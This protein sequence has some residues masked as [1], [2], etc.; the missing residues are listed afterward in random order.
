MDADGQLISRFRQAFERGGYPPN[1]RVDRL[2]PWLLV[3][4]AL[5]PD[6][7]RQLVEAGVTH[8]VDLRAEAMDEAA[9]FHELGIRWHRIPVVDRAA[10]S[11][12]QLDELLEWLSPPREG[13]EPPLIVYLH[14]Q[15][16]LGRAPTM[17]AALLMSV[18][19]NR[20]DATRLVRGARPEASPT[21]Q[22]QDWLETL[23]FEHP[24][25]L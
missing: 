20:L 23:S 12:E 22:Q 14:C 5:H 7:Y 21:E 10:P 24:S 2:A 16:G 8:A 17:A 18:G 6:R 25:P 13:S 4:P 19:F 3:G 9:R 11:Q 15:G 1:P